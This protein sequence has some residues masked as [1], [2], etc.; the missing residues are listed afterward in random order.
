MPRHSSITRPRPRAEP[1]ATPRRSSRPPR[2]SMRIIRGRSRNDN[3]ETTVCPRA[4][5]PGPGR[6]ASISS[7]GRSS[8]SAPGFTR[9]IHSAAG[10]VFEPSGTTREPTPPADAKAGRVLGAH[11]HPLKPTDL[12]STPTA[13]FE[14]LGEMAEIRGGR[15]INHADPSLQVRRDG[16]GLVRTCRERPVD[17][18]RI[19]ANHRPPR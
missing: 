19:K 18:H 4:P 6:Q 10:T 3:R 1:L 12:E 17:M 14:F 2:A 11:S 7:A 8:S 15:V 16:P 9:A 5:G 13:T